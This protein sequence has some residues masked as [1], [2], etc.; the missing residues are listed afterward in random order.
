[1][2]SRATVETQM[3]CEVKNRRCTNQ[4]EDGKEHI[5]EQDLMIAID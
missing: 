1:M 4:I 2:K 5:D 3:K